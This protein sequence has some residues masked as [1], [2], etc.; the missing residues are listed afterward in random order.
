[1]TAIATSRSLLSVILDRLFGTRVQGHTAPAAPPPYNPIAW[2]SLG[3]LGKLRRVLLNAAHL[4]AADDAHIL[5]D[6][7]DDKVYSDALEGT[8]QL[9]EIARACQ[10]FLRNEMIRGVWG[11]GASVTRSRITGELGLQIIRAVDERTLDDLHVLPGYRAL[12]RAKEIPTTLARVFTDEADIVQYTVACFLRHD[13]LSEV[14]FVKK[15]L[16]EIHEGLR[17]GSKKAKR[18]AAARRDLH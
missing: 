8:G 2:L 5:F 14:A 10:E 13:Q 7:V 11:F 3:Q 12:I 4:A 15:T 17:A 18:T 6:S 9:S 16:D 1:M